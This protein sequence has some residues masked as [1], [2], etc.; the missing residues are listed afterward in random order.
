VL[1]PENKKTESLRQIQRTL[2]GERWDVVEIPVLRVDG[3]VRT[4]LWNSANVY[5]K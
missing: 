2:S 4:V 5:D 1:F 3:E